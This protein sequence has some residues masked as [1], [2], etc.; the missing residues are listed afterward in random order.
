MDSDFGL[1]NLNGKEE[2]IEAQYSYMRPL[3]AR[4]EAYWLL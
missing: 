4:S 1:L 2:V 3:P